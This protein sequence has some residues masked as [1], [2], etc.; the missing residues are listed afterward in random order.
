MVK[1]SSFFLSLATLLLIPDHILICFLKV[2]VKYQKLWKA[3]LQTKQNTYTMLMYL[4]LH[5][6]FEM[7]L[8]VVDIYLS[9][10]GGKWVIVSS[11]YT[12]NTSC[13]HTLEVS[14]HCSIKLLAFPL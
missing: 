1:T 10:L 14:G 8:R 11:R 9:L 3:N 4:Y 7:A 5:L 13:D 12:I 6:L 2:G